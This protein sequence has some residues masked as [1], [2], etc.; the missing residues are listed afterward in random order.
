M[1]NAVLEAVLGVHG[2][3]D[4]VVEGV[5]EPEGVG[6]EAQ[7]EGL[8]LGPGLEAGEL[9]TAEPPGLPVLALGGDL[10]GVD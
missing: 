6:L 8:G 2:A 4:D 7:G 1:Q 10:Q 9:D 5:G 3:D